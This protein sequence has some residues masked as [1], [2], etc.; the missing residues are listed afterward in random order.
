M[1]R[2]A[3]G[4]R[5]PTSKIRIFLAEDDALLRSILRSV[6]DAQANTEVVGVAASM[7]AVVLEVPRT[8]PDVW[9]SPG[10]LDTQKRV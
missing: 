6:I 8:Q 3:A 10:I 4:R 5:S 9:T 1:Q 2:R 7:Q